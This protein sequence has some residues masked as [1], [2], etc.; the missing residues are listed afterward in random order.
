MLSVI[1]ERYQTPYISIS[2]V[3]PYIGNNEKNIYWGYMFI[4][5]VCIILKADNVTYNGETLLIHICI[6]YGT[7]LIYIYLY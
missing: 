5:K 1:M 7:T 6:M 4:H 3:E 2:C